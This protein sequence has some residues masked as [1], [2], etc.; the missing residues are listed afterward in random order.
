LFVHDEFI[1]EAPEDRIHEAANR[2]S[3]VMIVGMR[4]VVP[5]VKISTEFAAAR[6]WYKGASAVYDENKRLIP[7]E[8]KAKK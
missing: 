1:I 7:W 3:E 5:D 4:E 8:P 2:L 6:R